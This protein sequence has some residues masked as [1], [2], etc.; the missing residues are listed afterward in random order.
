M[1]I[2]E[3]RRSIE[4]KENVRLGVGARVYRILWNVEVSEVES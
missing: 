3:V 1:E 4:M 2:S